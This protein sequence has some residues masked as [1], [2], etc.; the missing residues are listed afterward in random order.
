MIITE[1]HQL[2]GRRHAGFS[3]AFLIEDLTAVDEETGEETYTPRDLT[4]YTVRLQARRRRDSDSE[5]LITMD[6]DAG[7]ITVDDEGMVL[8]ELPDTLTG[9]VPAG[10][11]WYDM[12]VVPPG[13]DADYYVEG[14][15]IWEESVTTP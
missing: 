13:G 1:Q 10:T 6:T 12:R 2:R 5:L 9:Y 15:L 4:G 3:F 14:P 11:W 7:T 8:G